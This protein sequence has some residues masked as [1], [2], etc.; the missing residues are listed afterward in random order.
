MPLTMMSKLHQQ[1]GDVG[2]C[3]G[4]SKAAVKEEELT[5]Q[6]QPKGSLLENSLLLEGN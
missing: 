6:M 3:E 5:L 2:E 1:S 4:C